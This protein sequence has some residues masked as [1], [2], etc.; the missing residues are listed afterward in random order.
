[1]LLHQLLEQTLVMIPKHFIILIVY[2][3]VTQKWVG[4]AYASNKRI[5]AA[6]HAAYGP[7]IVNTE[8]PANVTVDYIN[9]GYGL[10]TR[11]IALQR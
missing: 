9:V 1:M 10:Q 11:G 2:L 7:L 8:D 5:Y 6:P 4:A 3:Q